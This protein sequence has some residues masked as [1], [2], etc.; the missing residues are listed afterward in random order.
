MQVLL[1]PAGIIACFRP[2]TDA[3]LF[4]VLYGLAAVYFSGVMVR[5]DKAEIRRIQSQWHQAS[6][7]Q[8]L[9]RG[10]TTTV[11][12]SSYRLHYFLLQVRLMLVL[13]PAACC[14]AG[15]GVDSLLS[16]CLASLKAPSGED[17]HAA[18]AAPSPAK[19]GAQAA[20]EERVQKRRA[21][22]TTK[23]NK[24]NLAIGVLPHA[25][26]SI[27]YCQ[28]QRLETSYPKGEEY[29]CTA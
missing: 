18:A 13:A 26:S 15:A 14:L 20:I 1:M 4:L 5:H 24:V 7:G 19:T 17:V 10:K 6:A 11:P 9:S 28:H 29:L 25:M 8:P 21:S 23:P 27:P 3:S 16:L 2:L 22:K 12:F